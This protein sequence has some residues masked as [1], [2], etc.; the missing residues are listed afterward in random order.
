MSEFKFDKLK[1]YQAPDEWAQRVIDTVNEEK[2]VPIYHTRC[3]RATIVC[4]CMILVC[5]LSFTFCLQVLDETIIPSVNVNETFVSSTKTQNATLY[6]P[7][8]TQKE[9]ENELFSDPT[10]NETEDETKTSTDSTENVKPTNK[11]PEKE[12]QKPEV[13]KPTKKP[14]SSKPSETQKPQKPESTTP[15]IEPTEAPIEDRVNCSTIIE[16]S[17]LST[18][19]VY[20]RVYDC[21]DDVY[22]GDDDIFSSQHLAEIYGST[23]SSYYIRYFPVK[24][25]VITKN[26]EYIVMFYDSNG[27][28]L[29]SFGFTVK[30]F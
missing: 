7:D 4:V 3:F 16:K 20:C 19:N 30:E 23:D 25:G 24:S 27:K 29:K 17:K 13:V 5:V 21:D 10:E 18:G 14:Q 11:K 2:T 8:E 12:T 6:E 15:Y 1:N 28:N 26:G 22:L 9:S